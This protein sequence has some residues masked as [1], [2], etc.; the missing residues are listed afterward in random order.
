MK[1]YKAVIVED[2]P[3]ARV[4]LKKL[5]T[6]FP[7]IEIIGEASDGVE[8]IDL[9]NTLKPDL[10]FLDI[11]MPEIDGLEMAKKLENKPFIIFTTAYNQ[12]ALD[13]FETYA[14]DYLT[15]PIDIK[16]LKRGI[17][18]LERYSMSS[19]LSDRVDNLI[20]DL[21]SVEKKIE[22][23]SDDDIIYLNSSDIVYIQS[24]GKHSKL[25]TKEKVFKSSF[26]I[27]KYEKVLDNRFIRIHRSYIINRD[28]VKQIV[29][30]YRDQHKLIM[31]DSNQTEIPVNKES[32]RRLD[33][34]FEF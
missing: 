24:D 11:E 8:G 5:L 2:E 18:R 6:Q 7:N 20:S 21:S 29:K 9:I 3:F 16:D 25:F 13:A 19:D 14:V 26:S 4:R 28:C 27:A 33:Q 15:K 23:R 1:K 30:W 12:Y 22:I 31:D 17:E 10:I 32:N 34:L